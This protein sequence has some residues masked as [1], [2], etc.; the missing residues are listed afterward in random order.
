M[1]CGVIPKPNLK[2]ERVPVWV[3]T[4]DGVIT[5]SSASRPTFRNH[6]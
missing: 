5:E 2:V 3:V 6:K 4:E 1:K